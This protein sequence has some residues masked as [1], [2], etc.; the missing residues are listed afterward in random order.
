M[1]Y[2]VDAEFA[3]VLTSTLSWVPLPTLVTD[4]AT[5]AWARVTAVVGAEAALWHAAAEL[6]PVTV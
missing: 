4:G 6:V 2:W 5:G 1:A 3:S